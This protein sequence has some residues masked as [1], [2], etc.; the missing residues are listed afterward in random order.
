MMGTQ[1]GNR[2]AALFSYRINLERRV[3]VDHL[4]RQVAAVLDLSLS[5]PPFGITMAAPA[6]FPWNPGSSSNAALALPL[7]NSSERELM[8]QI[9][10]RLD[11]LWFLGFDLDT[12][13][14]HHSV[15]SKARARWG[16]EL[17]QQLFV[18]T[19]TQC[20]Q[21]GLVQGRLLHIDSTM[22]KAQAAKDSVV[23]SGPELVGALRQ[24]FRQQAAKLQVLP[25]TDLESAAKP[26]VSLST[27]EPASETEP[28]GQF[29]RRTHWRARRASPTG[30]LGGHNAPAADTTPAG[31]VSHLPPEE[32]SQG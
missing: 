11:F 5:I 18:Q 21:A 31:G 12:E 27:P 9:R 32:E 26:E 14:P 30:H 7:H 24:A 4:L 17:F 29:N 22:V 2:Q 20:V 16:T 13:I 10:V 1:P 15:L 3:A 6:M 25:T 19:V 23:A 28:A 8:E